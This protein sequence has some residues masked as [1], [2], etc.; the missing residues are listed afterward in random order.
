MGGDGGAARINLACVPVETSLMSFAPLDRSNNC[1]G[2]QDKETV[3]VISR[4]EN[5]DDEEL[6][7]NGVWLATFGDDDDIQVFPPS[8]DEATWVDNDEETWVDTFSDENLLDHGA[9]DTGAT[10]L[11]VDPLVFHRRRSSFTVTVV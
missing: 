1:F 2:D 4:P 10:A 7:Y 8:H 5:E 9:V 3:G 11:I 6:E